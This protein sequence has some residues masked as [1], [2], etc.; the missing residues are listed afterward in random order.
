MFVFTFLP[1]GNATTVGAVEGKRDGVDQPPCSSGTV[2]VVTLT[3]DKL[4][5]T[6]L[7][8]RPKSWKNAS[9]SAKFG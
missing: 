5:R 9:S 6:N 8:T 4:L 1:Q 2:T 7:Q 3:P